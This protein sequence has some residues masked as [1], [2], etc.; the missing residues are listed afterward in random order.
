MAPAR[1]RVLIVDDQVIVARSLEKAIRSLADV[2]IEERPEAAL[3]RIRRGER[4]DLVLCDVMMPEMNG[5]EFFDRVVACA[6]DVGAGFVFISGGMEGPVKR[7][8]DATG[9]PCLI[10]PVTSDALRELVR[11][12]APR[13]Q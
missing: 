9:Q 10:K 1:P 3:D 5:P 2:T 13:R 6:P 8:L 12:V 11:Q 7:H 4:F